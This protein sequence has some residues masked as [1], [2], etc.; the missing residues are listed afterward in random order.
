MAV[1]IAYSVKNLLARKMTTIL[2]I[3]GMALV[4]FV[5]ASILM[6]AEGLRQTLVETGSPDNVVVIRKGSES[7]VQSGIEREKAYV[8]EAF[9]EIAPS[10]KGGALS[11]KEIVVLIN[12]PRRGEEK[13][14]HVQVRGIGDH[15]LELRPQVRIV[16]GGMPR[17]GSNEIIAGRQIAERFQGGGLG[18]AVRF[19]GREWRIVG[20]FEAGSTGFSSEIW[21]DADQLMQAFRRQAYSSVIFRLRSRDLLPVVQNRI[22]MDPR[23]T[24]DARQENVY[25]AQQSE[26]MANFLRILGISL[27]VIFSLGAVIGAMIT[28]YAAVSNRTAEIGT[29][30]ALGYQQRSILAAF[31]TESIFLGLSGG[32]AGL[33]F[34]SLLQLFT[35]STVNFQTFSELAFRFTLT[36]AIFLEALAFSLVMGL[37]GGILPALRASRMKIIEA[38]RT[39]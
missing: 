14:S 29:L 27:T 5:F 1:P 33:L 4:V 38:L 18:E 3:S 28:M 19:G 23:L 15:S 39:G 21:A 9:P 20:V 25:Y 35:I 32:I 22:E 8:I 6:M 31:M 16:E 2:T 12:L 30:R 7:E 17:S 26:M 34:A 24:L 10:G 36:P 37:A 11:A 13:E